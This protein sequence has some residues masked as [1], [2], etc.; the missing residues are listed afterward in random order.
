MAQPWR[1]RQATRKYFQSSLFENSNPVPF[2]NHPQ[3][4]KNGETSNKDDSEK[5]ARE[6]RIQA[7]YDS[8]VDNFFGYLGKFKGS[9]KTGLPSESKIEIKIQ[10]EIKI[11][12]EIETAKKS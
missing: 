9:R 4:Q 7:I 11:P 1:Q 8:K 5:I 12:N 10:E 3:T 6:K 2:L